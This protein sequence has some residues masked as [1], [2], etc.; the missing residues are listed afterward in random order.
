[1]M[2]NKTLKHFVMILLWN[3]NKR[4]K[5]HKAQFLYSINEQYAVIIANDCT[6]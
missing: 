3:T 1:M 4:S 2:S 5:R 6:L